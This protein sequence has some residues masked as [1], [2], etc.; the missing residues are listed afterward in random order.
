[1]RGKK[2]YVGDI[3]TGTGTL[4]AAFVLLVFVIF[5]L[6]QWNEQFQNADFVPD[7]AKEA[8]QSFTDKYPN[9]I[10]WLFPALFLG[11]V[12]YTVITA[13]LIEVISKVWFVIGVIVGAFIQI[14][15]GIVG[16]VAD[17]FMATEVFQ[18]VMHNIPGAIW[19]FSAPVLWN[20]I[21]VFLVLISLYFK[22][23]E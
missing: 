4:L 9:M 22:K 7:R 21:W 15:S 8:Q 20:S 16:Y 10:G 2:G 12:L 1:M 5:I 13:Y 6:T 14:I 18:S 17:Q 11:L 19:Y 3:A 23:E